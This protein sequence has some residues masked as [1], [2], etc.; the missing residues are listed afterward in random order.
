MTTLVKC[1]IPWGTRDSA[2]LVH[3]PVSDG[4]GLLVFTG[5]P[6][7]CDSHKWT[8]E[9]Q[10]LGAQGVPLSSRV[11]KRET[12]PLSQIGIYQK[13]SFLMVSG[14]SQEPPLLTRW[15]SLS[16]TL[17][18]CRIPWGARDTASLVHLPESDG[19]GLLGPG[20]GA[21]QNK[22]PRP[23]VCQT[24]GSSPGGP[25]VRGWCPGPPGCCRCRSP[26]TR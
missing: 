22:T 2:S 8:S 5:P 11:G 3:L 10:T 16:S 9:A 15:V 12:L 26:R 1:R 25:G 14:Q 20:G 24:G 17:V 4:G 7:P 21:A 19:D 23:A 6:P 18:K 13:A